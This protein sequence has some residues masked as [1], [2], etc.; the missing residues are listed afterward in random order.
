MNVKIGNEMNP[1][2]S[3]MAQYAASRQPQLGLRPSV[4]IEQSPQRASGDPRSQQ[5]LALARAMGVNVGAGMYPNY[6]NGGG[7][8][9]NPNGTGTGWTDGC[10][11]AIDPRVIQSVFMGQV[12]GNMTQPPLGTNVDPDTWA[13]LVAL[14]NA[15]KY[16]PS[17]ARVGWQCDSMT[18]AALALTPNSVQIVTITPTR[19]FCMSALVGAAGTAND[20]PYTIDT[21][22]YGAT[23]YVSNGPWF[24]PYYTGEAA[25]CLC[26]REV[27]IIDPNTPIA[28]AIHSR[29]P[30]GGANI[31]VFVQVFGEALF[32]GGPG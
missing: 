21:L 6:P 31:D 2:A 17:P 4:G 30:A 8:N 24:G 14:V 9:G 27:P 15:T 11:Q 12:N 10:E 25:C 19:A 18:F 5:K 7:G 29:V 32:C 22:T 16:C 26:V 1:R 23:N 20:P 3:Q 28:M 13:A